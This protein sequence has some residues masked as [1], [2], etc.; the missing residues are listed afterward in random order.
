VLVL[1]FGFGQVAG[2]ILELDRGQ[3][4]PFEGNYSAWL[5]NKAKRMDVEDKQQT[6]L[7]RTIHRELEWIRS[8]AKGQQKKGKA[9]E[10]AYDELLQKASEYQK[11]DRLE[12]MFLP[13]GPRL[14]NVVVEA[15]A[16]RKG[17]NGRLLVDNLNFSLPPGGKYI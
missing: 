17:F 10:R 9:R 13:P 3:G 5:D 12:S 14:G 11:T 4:I 6:A 1:G 8:N 16:L 7:Q 15:Q 2:W